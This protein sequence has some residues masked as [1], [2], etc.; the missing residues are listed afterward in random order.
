MDAM[1]DAGELADDEDLP[2]GQQFLT[3]EA[4]T[5]TGAGLILAGLMSTSLFQF[6]S[7]FLLDQSSGNSSP[8][9]QYAIFTGPSGL[10][11]AAGAVIA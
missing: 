5:F 7:F 2:P 3:P 11:A 6:L 1:G 4:R 8:T 10:L 9:L